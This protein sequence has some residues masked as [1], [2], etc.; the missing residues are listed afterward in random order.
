MAEIVTAP[1]IELVWD[2]RC[3]VGESPL[4]DQTENRILFVDAFAG[5][6][7]AHGIQDGA[8]QRWD[9][10]DNI[11]SLGLCKSGRLIVALSRR[12]VFFDLRSGTIEGLTETIREPESNRLNDGKVGPDGCFW[13]GSSNQNPAKEPTCR[14]YRVTPDGAMELKAEGYKSSNGLAWT[15]DG[16]TMFHS[17][18]FDRY[19]EAW[20]FDTATG[21]LSN[22]RRIASL[23]EEEGR[24][25]GAA[26]DAQGHYWSA[27]IGGS[28]LNRFSAKGE[29]LAKIMLPVPSPSMPCFAGES[30]FITSNRRKF[31]DDL[32]ARYPQMG[33]LFRMKASAI[34]APIGCFADR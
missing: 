23:S 3:F 14:L 5:L 29:L 19:I 8:R 33:G 6:I 20:D 25:D 27:G 11:G 32:L 10:A 15:P 7:L 22:W 17:D 13:V 9:L 21:K 16:G 34:G 28:C 12:V 24:P 26:C 30:L 1:E 31:S 4:W 18:T 2:S